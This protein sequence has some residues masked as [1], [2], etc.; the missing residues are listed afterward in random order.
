MG[1]ASSLI[2]LIRDHES[3]IGSARRSGGELVVE[4]HVLVERDSCLVLATRSRG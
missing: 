4:A 2:M 3:S 1:V